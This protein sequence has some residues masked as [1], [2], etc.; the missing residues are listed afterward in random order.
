MAA[1]S[2]ERGAIRVFLVCDEPI[3]RA[4]LRTALA[5]YRDIEVVGDCSSDAQPLERI[6]AEA[7]SVIILDCDLSGEHLVELCRSLKAHRASIGV[8][9]QGVMERGQLRF[10]I[11]VADGLILKATPVTELVSGIRNLNRGRPAVDRRLWPELFG[12]DLAT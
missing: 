5:A 4:R 10:A 2:D 3:A 8:L 12:D 7:A 11:E 6:E 9:L 1:D